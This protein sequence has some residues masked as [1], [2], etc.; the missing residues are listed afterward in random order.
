MSAKTIKS[1][2]QLMIN[3]SLDSYMTYLDKIP[4]YL[5]SEKENLEENIGK[6]LKDLPPEEADLKFEYHF[7]DDLYFFEDYQQTFYDSFYI[8]LYSFLEKELYKI[9]KNLEEANT[10]K[11]KI[12]YL[13]GHGVDKYSL[14][15]SSLYD[16]EISHF[17]SWNE[18]KN[19]QKIRN[20][21][22]HND[23]SFLNKQHKLFSTANCLGCLSKID[24]G[25]DRDDFF[26]VIIKNTTCLKLI[27]CIREFFNELF[28]KALELK[29]KV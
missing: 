13:T 16:I 4:F 27:K 18:I 9:C 17:N 15:L 23:S 28:T 29:V 2:S 6:Q 19:H 11:I 21:I 12:K 8:T 10:Y 14:Y 22:V 5:E 1:V 25:K 20:H 24:R 3:L 7:A 26:E